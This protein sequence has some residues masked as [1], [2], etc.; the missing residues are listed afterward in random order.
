MLLTNG[1]KRPFPQLFLVLVMLGASPIHAAQEAAINEKAVIRGPDAPAQGPADEQ[2]ETIESE[3]AE[4]QGETE[5]QWVDA[6]H[7]YVAERANRLVQWMDDFYGAGYSDFEAASSRIRLRFGYGY[8]ELDK[9]DFKVRV[10]GKI[11]LPKM[12]KRLA[13]V[14]EGEEGE[15]FNN[16]GPGSDE[17]DGQLGLQYT[18]GETGGIRYDGILG[19]NSSADVRLGVR[20]RHEARYSEKFTGR[21]IQDF[22]Y[23]TGDR[24]AFMRTQADAFRRLDDDNLLAWVNRVEYGEDTYGVEWRSSLQW[25]HRLDD[26]AAISY[27]VGADGVTDPDTLTEN[28]G[29]AINYRTSIYRKFLFLQLEPY[30]SWRKESDFDSRVGVWGGN[31]RFEIIF[32]KKPKKRK[33]AKEQSVPEAPLPEEPLAWQANCP[34]GC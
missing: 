2:G 34:A 20:L 30:Y 22:A 1:Q 14:V 10:R 16:V 6:S 23:Q 27:M 13:L 5:K 15:D 3:E 33:P 7:D 12:S 9:D 19:I 29:F 24:G 17:D 8:D 28:Y 25:R 32:E 4:V 11:Q 31:V 21:L 26:D 18:F